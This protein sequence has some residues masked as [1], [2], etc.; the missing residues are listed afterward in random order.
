MLE[1]ENNIK[2]AYIHGRTG[3]HI[4]H[5]KL[6]KS[7]NSEFLLLINIKSGTTLK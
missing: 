7:I 2:I 5:G 4:M 3:P 6:A 1:K